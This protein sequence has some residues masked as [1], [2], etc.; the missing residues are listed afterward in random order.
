MGVRETK[1]IQLWIRLLQKMCSKGADINNITFTQPTDTT[2][3]D[4]CEHGIGGFCTSGLAWRYAL[5]EEMQGIFSI[6]VLEFLAA[7]ITIYMVLREKGSNRKVLAFTDSSSALGWMHKASFNDDQETHD[8]VA[9]FLA[10]TCMNNDSSL[11]S[12]H[13]RG[14]HNVLADSLSRD[15]HIT[16]N[17]LT[18]MLKTLF[19]E[20]AEKNFKLRTLPQEIVSWLHSLKPSLTRKQ[21]CPK[22]PSRSKLGALTDGSDTW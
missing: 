10:D 19:P 9:R 15:T 7:A 20:Q 18:F 4:A 22:A 3:S 11:Y 14:L 17:K 12:Q 6:N 8:D 16:D 2:F 13:I 1:D 21:E 5:P